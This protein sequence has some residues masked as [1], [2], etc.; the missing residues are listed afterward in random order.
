MTTIRSAGPDDLEAVMTLVADMARDVTFADGPPD[1]A[2]MRSQVSLFLSL[3]HVAV[4]VAEAN[5]RIIG[6]YMAVLYQGLVSGIWGAA[7]LCWYVRPEHRHGVGR[8]LLE[9]AIRW[10]KAHG[11]SRIES[12]EET[13]PAARYLRSLGFVPQHTVC[14]L[15]W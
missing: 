9:D 10:A 11:A 7:K 12:P 15:T 14:A 8:Q 1:L 6:V 3:P 4:L 2:H 13:R 5:G